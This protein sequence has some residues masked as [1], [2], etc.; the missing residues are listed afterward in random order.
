MQHAIPPTFRARVALSGINPEAVIHSDQSW[1]YRHA[2]ISDYIESF[3]N[4][5]RRHEHLG[6]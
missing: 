2:D 5:S 1:Q 6:A 3:Y 4:P